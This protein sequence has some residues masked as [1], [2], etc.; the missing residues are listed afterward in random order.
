MAPDLLKAIDRISPKRLV[1][2]LTA[3]FKPEQFKDTYR[4]NVEGLITQKQTGQKITTVERLLRT[5]A[6][7]Q[8]LKRRSSFFPRL[9]IKDGNFCLP[10]G[11]SSL[12]GLLPPASQ[13]MDCRMRM[14]SFP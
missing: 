10:G 11:E 1:G 6:Y 12:S 8:L 7:D 5:P 4:E 9:T 13:R 14:C 2:H 3:P